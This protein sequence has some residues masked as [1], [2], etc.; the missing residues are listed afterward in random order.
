VLG[1][2][3]SA[4]PRR[5]DEQQLIVA[6]LRDLEPPHVRVMEILEDQPIQLIR[7]LAGPQLK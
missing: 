5:V 2:A 1:E 3:V 6:A 4:R 7:M